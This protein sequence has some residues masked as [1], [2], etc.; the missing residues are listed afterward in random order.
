MAYS[1][2]IDV[3][4]PVDLLVKTSGQIPFMFEGILLLIF[5]VIASS[6]YF[7]QQRRV[8]RGN[9]SQAMAIASLITTTGGFILFLINGL[10]AMETLIVLVSITLISTL[11][12]LMSKEEIQI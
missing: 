11:W 3:T 6:S 8:G 9:I 10:I 5:L 7:A 2:P 1:V 4:S 12:F